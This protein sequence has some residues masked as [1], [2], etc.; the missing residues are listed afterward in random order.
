[1][2]ECVIRE[3]SVTC[4]CNT[5]EYDLLSSAVLGSTDFVRIASR[6]VEYRFTSSNG[7]VRVLAGPDFPRRDVQWRNGQEPGWHPVN[8]TVCAM[9]T[10][11]YIR[12]DDGTY[13]LGLDRRPKIGSSESAKLIVPYIPHLAPMTSSGEEPFT[14]GGATRIDLRPWHQGIVHY[15]AYALEPLRGDTDAADKQYQ[16][17]LSYV[18]RF[19]GSMR[20]KAGQTLRFARNYLREASGRRGDDGDARVA[21]QWP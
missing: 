13:N 10:G 20:D 21:R 6:G 3:S 19:K 17:F 4:S 8:S 1:M 16:T 2:T 12:E 7:R 9:P 11:Y 15:A 18:E 5:F 14:V